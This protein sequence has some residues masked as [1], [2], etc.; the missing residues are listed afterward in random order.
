MDGKRPTIAE[1]L[2]F[3]PDE[4]ADPEPFDGVRMSEVKDKEQPRAPSGPPTESGEF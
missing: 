3:T 4:D 1:I 2:G